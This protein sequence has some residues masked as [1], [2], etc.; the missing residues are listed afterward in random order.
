VG[1]DSFQYKAF[2]GIAYSIQPGTVSLAVAGLKVRS[3]DFL[4]DNPVYR[5]PDQSNPYPSPYPDPLWLDANGDG[6]ATDPGDNLGPVCYVRAETMHVTTT[7]TLD[8]SWTN[9]GTIMISAVSNDGI[10]IPWT[11][12]TVNGTTVT[13][14]NAAA[15]TA[16]P[17]VVKHY[18]DLVL[19][20][21]ATVLGQTAT[22][23]VGTTSND[24]YLTYAQPA[25]TLYH[26]VLHLGSHYAQGADNETDVILGVWNN[27]LHYNSVQRVDGIP[28]WYYHDYRSMN[29]DT[30]TLLI[31]HATGDGTLGD[32]QCNAWASLMLSVLGAQGIQRANSHVRIEILTTGQ[33]TDPTSFFVNFW[34]FG[35]AH[36]DA[37]IQRAPGS[38]LDS[39][40]AAYPYL[41]V[42]QADGSYVNAQGNGYTFRFADV[43][44]SPGTQ[45]KGPNNNPASIFARHM[46]TQSTIGTDTIWFDPSYGC[47]YSGATKEA[48]ELD[49]DDG[50]IAAYC[51]LETADVRVSVIQVDLNGDGDTT[52]V[53][54]S[55]VILSRE[56]CI[57]VREVVAIL[58]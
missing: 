47:C 54:A 8:R 30:R 12:A 55:P 20:W 46:F 6:D 51:V 3:V 2:D 31:P 45:G 53:V 40:I 7:F 5:D 32:G 57:G 28:L 36:A 42:R 4:G 10:N 17:N 14:T 19:Y 18:D 34:Q 33:P 37:A 1:T 41:N 56:N 39:I 26:T 50:S 9:G 23:L 25:S 35:T 44:D 27:V 22:T 49:F 16:F 52:D 21:Y 29:T 24:V 15:S 58:S 38:E 43:T 13:I 48:R 11:A